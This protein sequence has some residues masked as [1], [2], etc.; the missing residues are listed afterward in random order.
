MV[1]VGHA[2]TGNTR[3]PPGRAQKIT[4][5]LVAGLGALPL[6]AWTAT[7]GARGA[8]PPEP[9]DIVLTV[10]AEVSAGVALFTLPWGDDAGQVG[11][12]RRDDEEARGPEAFAVSDDG[13]FALIDS[14][15]G[16]LL[17]LSPA[18][19]P[20][21]AIPLEVAAPRFV[22]ATSEHVYVLDADQ[23]MRLVTYTW[24][25]VQSGAVTVGPFDDPVTALLLDSSGLP[26]VESGHELVTTIPDVGTDTAAAIA[27][28]SPGD[29]G[30]TE[31]GTTAEEGGVAE[32][33][34]AA[35]EFGSAPAAGVLTA[36]SVQEDG[37]PPGPS[38]RSITANGRPTPQDPD[39]R[40][41]AGMIR[42]GQARVEE[43]EEGRGRVR[44]WDV[45]VK[46]GVRIDHIISLD[47]LPTG[48]VVLGLRAVK[49][50][51]RTGP[52][53]RALD[54]LDGSVSLL[55]SEIGDETRTLALTEGST[56]YLG[57]PYVVA[58]DGTIYEPRATDDGY[59]I[60]RHSFDEVAP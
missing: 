32:V 42:R 46:P 29:D 37:V 5:W 40:V 60:L 54:P 1:D 45:T 47:P 35:E 50:E 25:G 12:S 27:P 58:P 7:S 55:I 52:D 6:V 57:P 41:K 10:P 38:R 34:A 16:R 18:G 9:T 23:D 17:L 21:A 30:D 53:G 26:V 48:E 39:R 43:V 24:D 59:Q 51:P 13:R 19:E 36:P 56:V 33:D 49:V 22:A 3:R 11:L 44:G 14:V 31:S 8:G 2:R 20:L 28:S 4:I 15:N